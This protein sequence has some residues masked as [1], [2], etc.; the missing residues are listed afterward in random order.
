MST[1]YVC[2][3]VCAYVYVRVRACVLGARAYA[4]VRECVRVRVRM[5][6]YEC[7]RACALAGVCPHAGTGARTCV[8]VCE[9]AHVRARARV[10]TLAS[11]P[12]GKGSRTGRCA[13]GRACGRINV[14][15]SNMIEPL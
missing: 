3:Y 2:Q 5:I 12:E 9:G 1:V 6:V 7:S 10:G 4:C 15:L 11:V 8:R 13:C 14:G